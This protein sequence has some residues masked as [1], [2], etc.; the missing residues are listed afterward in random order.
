MQYDTESII[1]DWLKVILDAI[2]QLVSD[3]I[4]V[5]IIIIKIK[6]TPC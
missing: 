2:T 5:I 3:I 4:I 1:G 6:L